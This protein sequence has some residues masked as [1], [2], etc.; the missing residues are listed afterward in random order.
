MTEGWEKLAIFSQYGCTRLVALSGECKWNA[1]DTW[2][3]L[4]GLAS[5][6]FVHSGRSNMHCCHAFSFALAGLF[7]S[8][9]V[10]YWPQKSVS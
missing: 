9:R 7:L 10:T 2:C 8:R 5:L 4:L 3:Q 1:T 6:D